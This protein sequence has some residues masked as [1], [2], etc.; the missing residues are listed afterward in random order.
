M[1]AQCH[2]DRVPWRQ[3][4]MR[5]GVTETGSHR[6]RVS[7]RHGTMDTGCHG[8]IVSLRHRVMGT[9]CYGRHG[10]IANGVMETVSW[11]DGG[12]VSWRHLAMY[13]CCH[14]VME[15]CQYVSG[16]GHV[17][18]WVSVLGDMNSVQKLGKC[19]LHL[20]L[21][22][23]SGVNARMLHTWKRHTKIVSLF[24]AWHTLT[25]NLTSIQSP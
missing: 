11:T 16:V 10:G 17:G 15:T 18:G 14:G 5:Q 12:I 8:D 3:G 19:M 9:W 20:H 13:I 7:Q 21:P 24:H 25:N 6:D 23:G 22:F 2:G 1:E 4:V